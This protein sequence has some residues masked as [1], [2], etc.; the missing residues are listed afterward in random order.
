MVNPGNDSLGRYARVRGGANSSLEASRLQ[1]RSAEES[2]SGLA[3][4]AS[5]RYSCSTIAR[6]RGALLALRGG[7]RA[8]AGG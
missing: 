1:D 5:G 7:V 2:P 6:E 3:R 4:P 8:A